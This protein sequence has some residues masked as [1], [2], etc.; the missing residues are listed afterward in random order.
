MAFRV[1]A[2]P[3]AAFDEWIRGQ[4]AP[5]IQPAM[6]SERRGQDVFLRSPC[7]TCHTITGTPAGSHVGPDLTHVGSRLTLAAG[8][9]P[10]TL[11]HLTMWVR[12]APAIRPGV[13]MPSQAIPGEDLDA[14]VSY[15]RSLR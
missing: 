9:L 13:R 6:E 12:N 7:V 4:R 2:E 15:L 11:D 3:R 1:V 5:A 8:T 14:L 10:N